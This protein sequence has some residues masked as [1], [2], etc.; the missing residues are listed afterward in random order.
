MVPPL[1]YVLTLTNN[2]TCPGA[3]KIQ[4]SVA[5]DRNEQRYPDEEDTAPQ[6]KAVTFS[7]FPYYTP[8]RSSGLRKTPVP[9]FMRSWGLPLASAIKGDVPQRSVFFLLCIPLMNKATIVDMAVHHE[10]IMQAYIS[11]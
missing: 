7:I 10:T 5:A 9:L 11:K 3:G 2:P 8:A 6:K 4:V 1:F